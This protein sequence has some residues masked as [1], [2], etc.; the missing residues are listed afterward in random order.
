MVPKQALVLVCAVTNMLS[1]AVTI[2]EFHYD[3]A[4]GDKNEFI[5][6]V[7][8]DP[9]SMSPDDIDIFFYN[10]GD[11]TPYKEFNLSDFDAHGILSD[12]NAYY[13]KH[14]T[15]I[16][17]G[18]PDGFAVTYNNT[19]FEFISYEGSFSATSGPAAGMTSTDIL[20]YEATSTPPNSSLQRQCFS[21]TWVLTEGSNT[22]GQ[23][24]TGCTPG[25][26][27]KPTPVPEPVPVPV[28]GA[29]LL[30]CMGLGLI[31]ATRQRF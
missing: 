24:N 30:T 26:A 9:L 17:N 28:P 18:G 3:N 23:V 6:I 22:R 29:C 16:Q 14:V 7:L 5:E 4:G 12:S 19:V 31:R 27:P 1:A 25:P 2:N 15:G 13:S 10:G 11:G 20:V 8:T 21:D